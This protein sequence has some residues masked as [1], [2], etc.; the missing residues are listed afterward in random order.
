MRA[1]STL[2]V[3]LLLCAACGDDATTTSTSS[4][5]GPA[6]QRPLWPLVAGLRLADAYGR[7]YYL[8]PASELDGQRVLAYGSAS[9]PLDHPDAIPEDPWD[10]IY[11]STAADGDVLFHGRTRTGLLA[12]PVLFLPHEVRFGM[13]WEAKVGARTLRFEVVGR[14]P[15]VETPYGLTTVWTLAFRDTGMGPGSVLSLDGEGHASYDPSSQPPPEY[16]T[17]FAE[18]YGPL[19]ALPMYGR[20]QIARGA[21][22]IDDEAPEPDAPS[23]ALTPIGDGRPL[24]EGLLVTDVSAVDNPAEPEAGLRFTAY[25]AALL[26]VGGHVG[27]VACSRLVGGAL[28][29][30]TDCD[31]RGEGIAIGPGGD[32]AGIWVT[33]S[34]TPRDCGSCADLDGAAASACVADCGDEGVFFGED[35]ARYVVTEG[36]LGQ[37][38]LAGPLGR[39]GIEFPPFYFGYQDGDRLTLTTSGQRVGIVHLRLVDGALEVDRRRASTPSPAPC[40]RRRR[41]RRQ[42]RASRT[43]PDGRVDRLIPA[44]DGS[45]AIEPLGR[46]A[47]PEGH[48][49]TGALIHDGALLLLTNRGY[50]GMDFVGT[51]DATVGDTYAWTARL[52]P[53]PRTHDPASWGATLE[54]G[55]GVARVCWPPRDEAATLT[56]WTW[57][58]Q[59]AEVATAASEPD[60]I[61]LACAA[62]G[63]PARVRGTVPG[64]G[65]ALLLEASLTTPDLRLPADPEG[66]PP[67][68]RC[69]ELGHHPADAGAPCDDGLPCTDDACDGAGACV[70]V[71][72]CADDACSSST[73]TA[74]GCTP[75]EHAPGVCVIDGQ[76]LAAGAANPANPCQVCR[77]D[78]PD[79]WS[80]RGYAETQAAIADEGAA[81]CADAQLGCVLPGAVAG[82]CLVCQP[83]LGHD[84]RPADPGQTCDD[85][86]PCSTGDTCDASGFCVPH[87]CSASVTCA[88]TIYA[89]SGEAF[90]SRCSQCENQAAGVACFDWSRC[91]GAADCG[92]LHAQFSDHC[93]GQGA[94][95]DEARH[96]RPA[97]RG[98]RPRRLQPVPVDPID[99]GL[100][101]IV[102]C[103]SYVA[104]PRVGALTRHLVMVAD[105][106]DVIVAH[107]FHRSVEPARGGRRADAHRHERRRHRVADARR[108]RRVRRARFDWQLGSTGT[109]NALSLVSDDGF[110]RAS[111]D[112][113]RGGP[114]PAPPLVSR[115]VALP[116]L[117]DVTPHDGGFV[118]SVA[119][120]LVLIDARGVVTPMPT[121]GEALVDPRG[122]A[123]DHDGVL[124]VADPGQHAVMTVSDGVVA[125]AVD[126]DDAGPFDRPLEIATGAMPSRHGGGQ[127]PW[128]MYVSD[129]CRGAV[130]MIDPRA[131][132]VISTSKP[133]ADAGDVGVAPDGTVYAVSGR[134]CDGALPASAPEV[135]SYQGDLPIQ[136]MNAPGPLGDPLAQGDGAPR[137]L[138]GM[139]FD[140]LGDRYTIFEGADSE[141]VV[142]APD[143]GGQVTPR[144]V[145]TAELGALVTVT[146]RGSELILLVAEGHSLRTASGEVTGPALLGLATGLAP[147]DLPPPLLPAVE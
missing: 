117:R 39:L 145:L 28:V 69:D 50:S 141:L 108:H 137:A 88:T 52:A 109:D 21:V 120:G 33:D 116:A 59:P 87:N 128:A 112:L 99:N 119:G 23:L 85:G 4:G 37:V 9:P 47:L 62:C 66:C 72:T 13:A 139:A 17:R 123:F 132:A 64:V 147:F 58:D 130:Y 48:V 107:R 84:L 92:A 45:M 129:A 101:H 43:W 134:A 118:G 57:N 78:S 98:L 113:A 106:R 67:C 140:G 131:H 60:C 24:F 89:P 114:D 65:R 91:D 34:G 135:V 42:P 144:R 3:G 122:L 110:Y 143:R 75:P 138:R 51:V 53:G 76:C 30:P 49:L 81:V 38:S 96:P 125:R 32:E 15:E 16:V 29:A 14:E 7:S 94:C 35:G 104:A 25:G 80:P 63:L 79:A 36:A 95:V 31:E 46:A 83:E 11:L 19:S 74:S 103:K 61:Y 111:Y 41:R 68:M 136:L 86:D 77:A 6:N 97:V 70:S 22:P 26:P 142:Y 40:T 56:G 5:V 124:W 121:R 10:F 133:L 71:S 2:F 115:A 8:H 20:D 90:A 102:E 55:S 18:G 1:S 12:E 127:W 146:S 82:R 54:T 105:N 126:H 44:D 73:C 100:Q 27:A 93:D